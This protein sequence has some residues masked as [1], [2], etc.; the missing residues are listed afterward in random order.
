MDPGRGKNIPTPVCKTVKIS[1]KLTFF[2]WKSRAEWF[3]GG[4]ACETKVAQLV[5]TRLSLPDIA[6]ISFRSK[7]I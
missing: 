6:C 5:P 2:D 4:H 7:A 1:H 3:L